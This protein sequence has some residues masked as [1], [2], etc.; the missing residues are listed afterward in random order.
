M[1][2]SDFIK[3]QKPGNTL[4]EIPKDKLCRILKNEVEVLKGSERTLR[5]NEI[6]YIIKIINSLENRG[7]SLKGTTKNITS[8]KVFNFLRQ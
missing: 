7:V 5:N 3:M 2:D 1:Q 6:K 4:R 8:Q